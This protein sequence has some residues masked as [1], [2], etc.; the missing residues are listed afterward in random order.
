MTEEVVV[1]KE[2]ARMLSL[3]GFD[4]FCDKEHL[5]I[6]KPIKMSNYIPKNRYEFYVTGHT[7]KKHDYSYSHTA[8]VTIENFDTGLLICLGNGQ[9]RFQEVIQIRPLMSDELIE[10]LIKMVVQRLFI[11]YVN[12]W[13]FG[14]EDYQ[15]E[16]INDFCDKVLKQIISLSS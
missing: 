7:D 10:E 6:S 12:I 13:R 11:N 14:E 4:E 5:T 8:L 15:R 3:N 1:C 2:A 9:Q 16:C